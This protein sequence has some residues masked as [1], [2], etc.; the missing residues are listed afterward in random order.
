MKSR[1]QE[2]RNL[3][4]TEEDLARKRL[5]AVRR[6]DLDEAKQI[7]TELETHQRDT[8]RRIVLLM[9]A[10]TTETDRKEAYDLR[11]R[12]KARV[13]ELA[14][15]ADDVQAER[16]ARADKLDKHK[17]SVAER[18]RARLQADPEEQEMNSQRRA[19]RDR[20]RA[21]LAADTSK[22]EEEVS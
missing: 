22:E 11:K 1:I 17:Q 4:G 19:E 8:R 14:L 6:N 5:A 15:E 9:D 3:Y 18:R 2:V 16:K 13:A 7:E 21:E 12:T 20:L 10:L